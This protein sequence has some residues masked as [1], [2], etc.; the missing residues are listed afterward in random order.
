[1]S[2]DRLTITLLVDNPRS[3]FMPYALELVSELKA[4]GHV[5]WL[6]ADAETI[7]TGDIAFFLSC[8]HI[9]LKRIRE[10]NTYNLVAHSS[11]LPRGRGWSPLTWEV[12]GDASTLMTVLFEADDDVDAGPIH[13]WNVIGLEGYELLDELHAK[14]AEAIKALVAGFV[15]EYPPSRP[16]QQT[17]D[18]S[19]YRR[20]SAADSELDANKT[21]AE[22]FNLLRV[23][24]NDA[25][26]A[27]FL[28][29]GHRYVL[30][31]TK[32]D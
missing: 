23:V 28:Y 18:P 25:Y 31:I 9:I 21:I 29:R 2:T 27:F 10:R 5:V 11:D 32:E 19:Y 15:H 30:R 13:A 1:M 8:E 3:W 26:P 4:S 24:D 12:L 22:Q 17:G 7:P 16:Q 6:L 14:Q 20:R